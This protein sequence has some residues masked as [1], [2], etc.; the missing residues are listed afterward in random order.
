MSSPTERTLHY[1]RKRGWTV[2]TVERWN[3][4]VGRRQDL[5]GIGDILAV[6]PGRGTLLVQATSA[7]NVA[8][9]VSK[10]ALAD[11]T[12]TLLAAGWRVEVWGWAKGRAAVV[13]K[14]AKPARLRVVDMATVCGPA[15]AMP[16]F[17]RVP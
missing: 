13:G 2:A 6:S 14:R 1:L 4:H 12:H 3:P 5:F 9:R 17:Y 15:A 10:L 11:V 8:A 7:D 16:S